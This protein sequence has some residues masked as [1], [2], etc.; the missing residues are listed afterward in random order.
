[1]GSGDN[2]R[3]TSGRFFVLLV[4]LALIIAFVLIIG[5]FDVQRVGK[6]HQIPIVS[7]LKK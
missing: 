2:H 3:Q 6:R 4:A 5:M 1:M 7:P